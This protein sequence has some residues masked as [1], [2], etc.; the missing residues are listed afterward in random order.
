MIDLKED[1][2]IIGYPKVGNTWVQF[3]IVNIAGVMWNDMSHSHNMPLFNFEKSAD[4]VMDNDY[5]KGRKVMVIIRHAGD[6]LV[7]LYM[8]NVYRENFP[9]YEGSLEDF[10]HDDI[11]GIDKYITYYIQLYSDMHTFKDTLLVKYE[12]L[13]M[14]AP[15][16]IRKISDFIEFDLPDGDERRIS[17]ATNF[18]T[19]K[20]LELRDANSHIPALR[21]SANWQKTNDSFKIR[22]GK[23]G[24][25]VNHFSAGTAAYINKRM[26]DLPEFYGY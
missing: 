4:M 14:S 13:I 10:V 2:A 6:V 17:L 11:Y 1:L 5:L 7:S 16:W 24:G 21:R 25:Y 22:E 15:Q 12:D 3:I 19:M 20:T 26:K 18:E 8:H 9:I 23:V